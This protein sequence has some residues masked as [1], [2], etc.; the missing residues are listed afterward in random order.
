MISDFLPSD[1]D[2]ANELSSVVLV[3]DDD[4]S[5]R[6]ALDNLF[7]SVGLKVKT[8]ECATRL[9]ATDLPDVATCMVLDV[10]MP[11]LGGL[12]LQAKLANANIHVPVI[13]MTSHG[14]IPM[15]VKAMKAGAVDFLSKPFRDQD[16]LDAVSAALDRDRERRGIEKSKVEL[17]TLFESLTPSERKVMSLVS[18]GMMNK[19]VAAEIGLKEITVKVNRGKVMRKMHAK[20]LADLVRMAETL[21]IASRR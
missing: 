16:M 4:P 6:S 10:R 11:G 3:V 17:Q 5:I 21:G 15:T 20:S 18:S 7:S 1:H 14:D 19:S 9:L 2:V 8:F 12:E 13:I